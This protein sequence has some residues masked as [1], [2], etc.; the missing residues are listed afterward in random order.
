VLPDLIV[1]GARCGQTELAEA[2]LGRLAERALAAGTPLALGLLARSR[3][4]LARDADAEA[5]Y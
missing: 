2:A 5:L 3:A 1:A 4:L